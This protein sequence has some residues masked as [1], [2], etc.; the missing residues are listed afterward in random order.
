MV[1]QRSCINEL[2][3]T[4]LGHQFTLPP[5]TSIC[6]KPSAGADTCDGDGGAALACLKPVS[7][8]G[9]SSVPA[10]DGDEETYVQAGN[11]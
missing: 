3:L 8:D 7:G 10:N 9:I 2:R 11:T 5:D 1:S 4:R 6:A